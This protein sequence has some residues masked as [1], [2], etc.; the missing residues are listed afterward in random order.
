MRSWMFIYIGLFAAIAVAANPVDADEARFPEPD[1]QPAAV[2][3][4]VSRIDI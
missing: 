1:I 2:D 3:A 4:A